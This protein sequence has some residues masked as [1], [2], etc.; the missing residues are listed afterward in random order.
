MALHGDFGLLNYYLIQPEPCWPTISL[1]V[2]LEERRLFHGR[3]SGR[4]AVDPG[5]FLRRG[6]G[7]RRGRVAAPEGHHHPLLSSTTL[8]LAVVSVLG[9]FQ[10]F[11]EI[12]IM[13]NGG[14]LG[15]TTTIVYHIYQ[16]AF[17]FFDMGYASAMAFGMFAMMFVIAR[18]QLRV[19]RGEVEY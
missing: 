16:T 13:T 3:L 17:K 2:H 9:A 19:M 14:P 12:F 11:T 7:R 1:A 15:R 6:Q 18:R 4:V 10:V 8:F 5:G